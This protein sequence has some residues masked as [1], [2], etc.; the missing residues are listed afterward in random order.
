[1]TTVLEL[2]HLRTLNALAETGSLSRAAER[3]HLSQSALSH[4]LRILERHYET[5]LVEREARPL[6]LTPAGRCLLELAHAV[7][8]PIEDAERRIAQ[9]IQ[10]EAGQ[11]RI[12]VECHTCFDWLMPAMDAFRERWPE[13][14]MDIVSGF[15]SDA[16]SLLEAGQADLVVVHDPI[17]PGRGLRLSPLFQYET[18][19]LMAPG[20]R[21]AAQAALQ[22]EDFRDEMLISYPVPDDML[23]V[24]KYVLGPAGVQPQRRTTE[25]TVAILQLVASGRGIAALPRWSVQPYLERGYVAARPIGDGLW[26][27][28]QVASHASFAELAYYREFIRL[29]QDIGLRTMLGTAPLAKGG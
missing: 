23:D 7:L 24:H 14:E 5:P 27:E 1:M 10:G 11:L 28:L 26:C 20:H 19:A 15:Q 21:L 18:V 12:A 8:P 2:R 4:Q 29:I 16:E 9:M 17:A 3:V 22:A 25:L 13:V 6:R